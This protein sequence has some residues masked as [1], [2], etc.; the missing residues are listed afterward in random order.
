MEFTH[1]LTPEARR[2]LA[3]HAHDDPARLALRAAQFPDLPVRELV[4]QL[5]ARQRVSAKLPTWVANPD[6]I[7]PPLLSLEQSSSERTARFKA[8]L[9]SGETLADLTGGLGVDA[10]AFSE[11]MPTVFYVEQNSD[12][13]RLAAHNL[14]ALGRDNALIF[15]RDAAEFLQKSP[16]FDWLYLDPARRDTARNKVFRLEECEPN[17][18]ILKELLLKRAPNVLLK[19]APMLDLDR[20]IGQLGTVETATV[21]AVEG[22]VKE[23]LFHLKQQAAGEPEIRAVNLLKNG[24]DQTFAF[25]RSDE[26][27][28]PVAFSAPQQFLYEPHAALLKAG[29][30]RLLAA[31]FG[32]QKLHPNSHLY[33]SEKPQFAFPGR[34]FAI[35]TVLK[36]DRKAVKAAL[37]EGRANLTV[38]NF[39]ATV[40]TLRKQLGLADGGNEYV[41]A[42]TQADGKP[43][44]VVAN[45]IAAP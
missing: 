7:F 41:F 22:E 12:L 5:A 1:L 35:R 2:F 28:A 40:E 32:L 37:P 38:R 19:A 43:T 14:P 29:A 25:R 18:L 39:P 16:A 30:Y 17:V 24:A 11:K 45:K 13:A 20:A 4:Q 33:T 26:A 3:E 23:L 8:G 27:A 6:M 36:P 21:L 10:W 9:V 31:R 44:L 15:N 42:T 34:I